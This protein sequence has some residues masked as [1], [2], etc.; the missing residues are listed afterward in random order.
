LSTVTPSAESIKFDHNVR[1]LA[2]LAN[3]LGYAAVQK[4]LQSAVSLLCSIIFALFAK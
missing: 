1:P 2:L 3:E 4:I